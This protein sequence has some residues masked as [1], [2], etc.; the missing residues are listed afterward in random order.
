[1][2][3]KT[4]ILLVYTYELTYMHLYIHK[5]VTDTVGCGK[6]HDFTTIRNFYGLN[7]INMLQNTIIDHLHTQTFIC[8]AKGM[9]I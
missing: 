1:M 4:K 5:C 6:S 3:S 2:V 7:T 8:R 9:Y